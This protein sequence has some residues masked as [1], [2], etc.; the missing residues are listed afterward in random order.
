MPGRASRME[1]A[2]GRYIEAAKQFFPRGITLEKLCPWDG[3][4]PGGSL[5]P[6]W[7]VCTRRSDMPPPRAAPDEQVKPLDEG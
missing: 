7:Q 3:S 4:A 5:L 2:P 1:N 6:R